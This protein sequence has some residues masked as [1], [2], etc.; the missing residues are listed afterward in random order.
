MIIDLDSI[1][2]EMKMNV[3]E[4]TGEKVDNPNM[5]LTWRGSLAGLIEAVKLDIGIVVN[6]ERTVRSN[7]RVIAPYF[8]YGKS[9]DNGMG[10]V[11][12]HIRHKKLNPAYALVDNHGYIYDITRD[13]PNDTVF[14]LD[15]LKNY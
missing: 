2:E 11:L 9:F 12:L 10:W 1:H 14:G 8:I 5:C 13:K 4:I 3:K 15:I 6:G 7:H